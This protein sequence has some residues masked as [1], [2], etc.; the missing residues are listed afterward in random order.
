MCPPTH[1][2]TLTLGAALL[3]DLSDTRL[4]F[5]IGSPIPS[6]GGAEEDPLRFWLITGLAGIATAL[7]DFA[8]AAASLEGVAA[9]DLW[10]LFA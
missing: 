5:P 10:L 4:R 1:S 6:P 2:R 9:W 7:A 8:A 3:D